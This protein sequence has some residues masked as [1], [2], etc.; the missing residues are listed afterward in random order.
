MNHRILPI[1]L[2]LVSNIAFS[3]SLTIYK[4]DQTPVNFELSDID[5][6]TFSI[7]SL[8]KALDLSNWEC[9][10][11]EPAPEKVSPAPGV[12]EQVAEGLKII[13][14]DNQTNQAI[15]LAATAD[16]PIMN[17]NICLKWKANGNGN[18]M[19]ITTDLYA[20]TTNWI[21]AYRMINLTTIHSTDDSKIIFDNTWYYTRISVG[22][23]NATSTTSTENYD[24]HGGTVIQELS[25]NFSD[26]VKTFTFGAKANKE[27]YV[28][29]G[30][31]R[32]E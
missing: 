27:S 24:N 1:L 19:K 29:L 28:I 7:T 3:Q 17:K 13:G 21:S 14:N 6:I 9:M 5:S 11:T 25:T 10:M 22:P 23:N 15:H 32:I 12:F 26:P 30:K 18:F 2:L 20:D 4:T 16:N 31:V 8:A